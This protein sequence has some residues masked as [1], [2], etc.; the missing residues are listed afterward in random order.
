MKINYWL[1]DRKLEAR[2]GLL[3][4]GLLNMAILFGV[5]F[6]LW[7]VFMN[8]KGILRMYTP[9]FGYSYIQW[10]LIG[11][12]STVLIYRYWPI[13][14]EFLAE[15]HPLFKGLLL[16]ALNL[17]FSVVMVKVVL[18]TI[19]GHLGVS[20]F[21]ET[22]LES[23]KINPYNSREY[24]S[25]AALMMGAMA[26]MIIPIWSLHFYNWPERAIKT[27]SGK[28]TSFLLV[29]FFVTIGFVLVLHPHFGIIFYPWQEFTAAFPWWEKTFDTLSGRV[30]LGWIVSWTAAIWFIQVTYEGYPI[31]LVKKQPWRAVAGVLGTFALAMVFFFGFTLFQEIVWG[32][33]MQGGK[34]ILAVDWRYLHAG[35]TAMFMLL[36]A[37]I[38]GIYFGNWPTKFAIEV[39]ILFRTLIIAGTTLVFYILYYKYSPLLLGTQKGYSDPQQFPLVVISLLVSLLLAHHWYFDRWPGEKAIKPMAE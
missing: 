35:E 1:D 16:L 8:P 21:S 30:N 25:M 38:H 39:N 12:L 11:V 9:M 6:A 33:P 37:L 17:I 28:H 19:V 31:A 3:G 14:Q 13:S 4:S 26:A 36:M 20:Y 18:Q 2:F 22:V 5:F 24:S 23:L 10:L 34:Y 32:P 7:Y 15:K 29:L 27:P